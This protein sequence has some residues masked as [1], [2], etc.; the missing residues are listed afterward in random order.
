MYL[1]SPP[2]PYP[3]RLAL[4]FAELVS[5]EVEFVSLSRDSTEVDMKQR[6]EIINGS[7][8]Y[9]DQVKDINH[10]TLCVYMC[11]LLYYST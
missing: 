3:R 8:T 5:R 6:R 2:G 10:C 11:V 7:V 4:S 1:L 9:K